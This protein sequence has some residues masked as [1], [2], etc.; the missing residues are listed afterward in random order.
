MEIKNI[1]SVIVNK[2]CCFDI[3]RP[4]LV[5]EEMYGK[6]ASSLTK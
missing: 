4:W 3:C 6:D 5:E 1:D 2:T